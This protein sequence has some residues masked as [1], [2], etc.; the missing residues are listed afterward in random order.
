VN[1]V[2]GMDGEE[3][4]M[5]THLHLDEQVTLTEGTVTLVTRAGDTG[6]LEARGPR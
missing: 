1:G 2:N 6:R 5:G 3:R 4:D